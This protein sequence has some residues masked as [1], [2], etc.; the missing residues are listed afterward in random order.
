MGA[1]YRV[2]DTKLHREVAIKGRWI[3]YLTR[4]TLATLWKVDAGG[5]APPVRIAESNVSVAPAWSPDRKWITTAVD[6][7][8]GVVSPDGARK[9]VCFDAD[10]TEFH[11]TIGWSHDGSTLYLLELIGDHHRLSAYDVKR[12]AVRVIRDYPPDGRFYAESSDPLRGCIL[13]PTASA[14]NR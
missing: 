14:G 1:V 9:R 6:G 13:L 10:Y 8:I 2:T 12:D 7:K 3:A 4:G 11:S 5:A